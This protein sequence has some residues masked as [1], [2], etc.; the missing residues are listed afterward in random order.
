MK[1]TS[2]L[3]FCLLASFAVAQ[4][5]ADASADIIAL[6]NAWTA[7]EVDNNAAALDKLLADT[8][9]ITQPDGSIQNKNETLAY[10]RDKANHWDKVVSENM[11]VHVYE[12]TAIVTGTYHEKGSSAG[13]PFE[14]HG[15]FTDT[16]IRRDGKWRC[17]AGH[18]SY[19]AKE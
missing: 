1:A 5:P 9:V 6:E 2:L 10:V 14:N 8:V 13:K 15:I 19:A 17:V 11:K 12:N 7:A 3:L 4:K 18:D 16:W